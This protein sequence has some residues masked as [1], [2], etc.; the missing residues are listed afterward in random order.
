M[1]DK[2]TINELKDKVKKFCEDRNWDQY[3]NAKELTIGIVTEASELLQELRFKSYDEVDAL[4]NDP[5]RRGELTEEVADVFYFL[6]RLV[7][8]YDID[9][10]EELSKKIQKNEGK[11]PVEKAKNSNKKYS[12]YDDKK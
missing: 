12:E 10:S 7:Q 8:K 9:L 6:L 5:K 4:F 1:D 2:A 3:H 11:Y